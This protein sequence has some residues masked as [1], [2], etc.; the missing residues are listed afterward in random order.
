MSASDVCC[1]YSFHR[2]S[3]N[4]VTAFNV[5]YVTNTLDKVWQELDFLNTCTEGA[6]KRVRMK[7]DT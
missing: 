6:F 4:M 2:A 5:D 3:H 1:G 7:A